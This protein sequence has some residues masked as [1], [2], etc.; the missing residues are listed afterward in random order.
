MTGIKSVGTGFKGWSNCR[1]TQKS[2][3]VR[4]HWYKAKDIG[5]TEL[6]HRPWIGSAS[7]TGIPF[8][9][10]LLGILI[11]I[12]GSPFIISSIY[13]INSYQ[14][15][16]SIMIEKSLTFKIIWISFAK[17][18]TKMLLS[19]LNFKDKILLYKTNV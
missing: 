11:E 4:A 19:T 14:I 10:I 15:I 17:T 12:G 13:K 1:Q 9:L 5:W 6:T 16:I 18:K 8:Q 2:I 7:L 3:G